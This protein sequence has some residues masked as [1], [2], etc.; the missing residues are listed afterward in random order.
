[1]N[2]RNAITEIGEESAM[3]EETLMPVPAPE[4]EQ[5]AMDSREKAPDTVRLIRLRFAQWVTGAMP[6][7]AGKINI[8]GAEVTL[9]LDADATWACLPGAPWA[10]IPVDDA[11]VAACIPACELIR[12]LIRSVHAYL[13]GID[14]LVRDIEAH[15]RDREGVLRFYLE[16]K[17]HA[18]VDIFAH[19]DGMGLVKFGT[20]QESLS[21]LMPTR[22]R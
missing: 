2:S 15:E 7:V 3:F 6:L 21:A 16:H 11:E 20:E 14:A 1:M 10:P 8:K 9:C 13:A 19:S 17:D 18:M 4:P 12:N 5:E 22:S